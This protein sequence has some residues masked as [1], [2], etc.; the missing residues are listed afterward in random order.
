MGNERVPTK[1]G[2]EIKDEVTIVAG[3]QTFDGWGNVSVTRNLESIANQFSISLFDKFEGLKRDW[4]LKSGVE[5][6]ININGDRVMTGNIELTDV[7]YS[8]E[9]RDFIVAGRSKAGDIVD[10]GHDGPC[11]YK[12]ITLDKLAEELIKPFG[13]KV[14]L[15]VV[16]KVIN[17]FAVKPGESV[18]EA[19][20]RAARTQGFFF[21]ST[22][23][24]N[25][26]LTRAARARA[27]TSLEQGV[28]ILLAGA[29]FDDSK[30]HSEYI[31]KGQTSGL[32][33]FFGTDVSQPEGRAKDL[34]ITRHRPFIMVAEGNT[35]AAQAKDRAQW[36]ASNRLAQATR[37]V[38]TVQGWTQDDGSLWDIN[39]VTNFK[40]TMLG[41]NRDLL[42]SSVTY[43]DGANTGKTASLT[44]VDPKSYDLAPEVNKDKK[45]DIFASLGSGF[46]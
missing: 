29:K 25:I 38:G 16:P 27:N 18:F 11:E 24:G 19:L 3:G 42:I 43:A 28:N 17:K 10:C 39:Q 9:N 4:P 26:R 36:E 31:V 35:D 8:D 2:K 34:G 12:N 6:K 15:S 23:D 20:D 45:D 44:L 41:L 32:A 13:L 40:S 1:K 14:F 21:I 30:R 7:N 5:V 22:R 33:D 46:A 37:I